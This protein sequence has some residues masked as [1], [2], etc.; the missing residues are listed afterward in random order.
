VTTKSSVCS[1]TEMLKGLRLSIEHDGLPR[2]LHGDVTRIRQALLNLV[3]N[4]VKFTE[5]GSITIRAEAIDESA[6]GLLV[7]FS[8]RDSGIGIPSEALPQLFNAFE[9]VRTSSRTYGGTGLGLAIT[10]QLAQLMGGTAGA[11]SQ[12]G[13][14]SYFWFT[15][16]LRHSTGSDIEFSDSGRHGGEATQLRQQFSAARVLVAED[17]AVNREVIAA[18]L[19]PLGFAV[20][21]AEDGLAAVAMAKANLYDLVLMDVQ[22]P[23]LDGLSATRALR[24]LPGWSNVP[25]VALTADV[26]SERRV[27][28]LGAGMD[29]FL[30][31]PVDPALLYACL[32]RWLNKARA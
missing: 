10:R 19:E 18:L 3:G 29:D 11:E 20:D 26:F 27:D 21:C 13:V 22:M 14:G 24:T 16:R 4:S 7:R 2:T 30:S 17:N 5:R 8:V 28:C 12:E 23:R 31:K 6:E 1:E 9:Q 25:I 15:A 32:L